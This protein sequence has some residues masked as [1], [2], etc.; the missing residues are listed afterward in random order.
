M[1]DATGK[2]LQIGDRIVTNQNGDRLVCGII[3]D[4]T[5]K[6]VKIRLTGKTWE[7]SDYTCLKFPEQCAKVE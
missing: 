3:E 5:T 1:L 7:Y 2:T 6:K 4:F